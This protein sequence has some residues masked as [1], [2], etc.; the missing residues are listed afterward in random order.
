MRRLLSTLIL[1][2]ATGVAVPAATAFAATSAG[3]V[4]P[5]K[6][7]VRLLDVAPARETGGVNI[8]ELARVGMRIYL[9]VGPGGAP[10]PATFAITSLT[11]HRSASGRPVIVAHVVDTGER[12]VDLS[13]QAS[14]TDGP[15]GSTAGPY[16]EQAIITL[17]PGQAGNMTFAPGKGLPD[18][19]WHANVTLV[20]GF[21]VVSAQ[22]TVEF[23]T[24]LAGSSLWSRLLII[25]Q[26]AV[27]VI[28]LVFALSRYSR[29]RRRRALGPGKN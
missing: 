11:G 3:P 10:P 8:I 21:T 5:Q 7:G 18:G 17:A 27:L 29:S 14:L 16:R 13:G 28:V 1:L 20:S 15:G 2:T 24:R 6:F 23:G 12:A 22:A 4:G 25:I 9:A 19:P 26:A